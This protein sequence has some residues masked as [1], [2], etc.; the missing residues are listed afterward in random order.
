MGWS[1]KTARERGL[2]DAPNN[3]PGSVC[4]FYK[5][6]PYTEGAF[7]VALRENSGQTAITYTVAAV[8]GSMTC[9]PDGTDDQGKCREYVPTA[10]HG[11]ILTQDY[12]ERYGKSPPELCQGAMMTQCM[13]ESLDF[14]DDSVT[15]TCGSYQTDTELTADFVFTPPKDF[16]GTITFQYEIRQYDFCTPSEVRTQAGSTSECAD[17]PP[18]STRDCDTGTG[19]GCSEQYVDSGFIPVTLVIRESQCVEDASY[20]VNG[21]CGMPGGCVCEDGWFG[22]RC[23]MERIS[24]A[25]AASAT[26][27]GLAGLV[28]LLA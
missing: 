20:C 26:L 7:K 10:T 5:D 28:A 8:D 4:N 2:P 24:G 15:C 14:D 25:A 6:N 3:P 11:A 17:R 16:T 12:N 19:P 9:A 27:A 1:Y 23:D 13:D 18:R 22:P 21:E